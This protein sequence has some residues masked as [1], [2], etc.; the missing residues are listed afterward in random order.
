MPIQLETLQATLT[1]IVKTVFTG[2]DEG[3]H[4]YAD[5]GTV[6]DAM[7]SSLKTIGW[8]VAVSMPIAGSTKTQTSAGS[9]SPANHGASAHDVLSVV[10]IRTNPRMNKGA[11]A[12]NVLGCVRAIIKALL[13]YQP[14]PGDKGFFLPEQSAFA[15]DFED[16]GNI[17]YDVR[18]LKNV[19][20]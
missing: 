16:A 15:P 12:K 14:A 20:L 3:K 7:E 11:T 13:S 5:D 19:P 17:T 1:T 8:C 10:T 2:P 18:V 4:I 9:K 6:N